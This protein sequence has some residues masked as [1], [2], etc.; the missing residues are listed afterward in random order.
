MFFTLFVSFCFHIVQGERGYYALK[1]YE[2]QYAQKQGVYLALNHQRLALEKK[3]K[4][5][6]AGSLD[7]DLL[8]ERARIMLSRIGENEFILP[9]K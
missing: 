6:R 2:Q 5:L 3:V 7:K 8:D 9:E 4:H 1:N